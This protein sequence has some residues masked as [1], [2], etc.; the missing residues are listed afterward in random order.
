MLDVLVVLAFLI[1]Y[2]QSQCW[3]GFEALPARTSLVL[4]LSY[5][6]GICVQHPEIPLVKT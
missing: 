4:A 3:C 2:L 5:E 1:R 6:T